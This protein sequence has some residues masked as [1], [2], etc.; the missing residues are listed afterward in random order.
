MVL[1]QGV[2]LPVWGWGNPGEHVIVTLGDNCKESIA[3]ERG[4]WRLTFSPLQKSSEPTMMVINGNK[5]IEIN[6]IIIGDVWICAGEGNMDFPLSKASTGKGSGND[7]KDPQLRFFIADKRALDNPERIGGGRWVVCTPESAPDFSAVGY[8]FARDIR[9]AQHLPIGMIQCTSERNMVTDWISSRGFSSPPSILLHHEIDGNHRVNSFTTG[10]MGTSS[11]LYHGMIAPLIPYAITGVIWYQGESHEGDLALQYRR[12]L[13]RLIRDWR[14]QWGQGAFP[15]YF[16][17]LAGFGGVEDS[18]V[19]SYRDGDGKPRRAWPWIR[20]GMMSALSLPNTGMADAVDLGDQGDRHPE[21]KLDVGRRLALLARHRVYSEDLIDSG[22]VFLG[23]KR[24]GSKLRVIFRSVGGGLTQGVPPWHPDDFTPSLETSLHGF[25]IS[26]ND[27]KWH[28]ANAEIHGDEVILSNDEV[29]DP[30]AVR[31][32]WNGCP[33]G[34]LYNKE[35]LP[36]A[37][38]RSDSYQP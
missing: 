7:L 29:H 28:P 8:F 34:N 30:V 31:Y 38:F 10:K 20:E 12:Q 11:S 22:P 4:F 23:M 19:E 24:E 37:P 2:T 18:L 1:Q 17:S 5:R 36:A 26:G 33:T 25:A 3:D 14:D 6:D 15:F 16:V 35:G 32:D 13:P 9:S 21:D 27:R